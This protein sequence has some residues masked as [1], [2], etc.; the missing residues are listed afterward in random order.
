MSIY[1]RH[2]VFP[3]WEPIPWDAKGPG[4]DEQEKG[5]HVRSLKPIGWTKIDWRNFPQG[6]IFRHDRDWF[7]RNNIAYVAT[8]GGEEL[9]LIQRDWFGFPDPPE[10]ALASRPAG[11]DLVKWTMWGSFPNLP[12]AW[13]VPDV[14]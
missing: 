1:Q 8:F 9:L 11:H 13:T 6:G 3:E 4:V 5:F 14:V 12:V 7:S 10:W 2:E